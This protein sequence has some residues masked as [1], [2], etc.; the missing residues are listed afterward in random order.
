MNLLNKHQF[1]VAHVKL[2]LNY[3]TRFQLHMHT[4][5]FYNLLKNADRCMYHLCKEGTENL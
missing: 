1:E 5:L 3:S 2:R 4:N